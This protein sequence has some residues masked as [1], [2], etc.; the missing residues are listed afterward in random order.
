VEQPAAVDLNALD[1]APALSV[2]FPGRVVEAACLHL[3]VAEGLEAHVGNDAALVPRHG[4][5]HMNQ[6]PLRGAKGLDLVAGDQRV[7]LGSQTYVGAHHTPHQP[8]VGQVV[9]AMFPAVSDGG[10]VEHVQIPWVALGQ[11]A[12]LQGD[13]QLLRNRQGHEAQHTQRHSVLHQGCG[14][15]PGNHFTQCTHS[16]VNWAARSLRMPS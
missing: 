11:K 6:H 12:L 15:L 14:L 13:Q 5:A 8:R 9:G 3:R 4:P 2:G 16:F 10:G 7:E 1:D